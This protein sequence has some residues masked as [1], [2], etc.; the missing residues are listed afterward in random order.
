VKA[1]NITLTILLLAPLSVPARADFKYTETAKVTGG[2]VKSA[3]K[4]AGVFS[5][6]AAQATQPVVTTRYVKGGRLRTDNPDGK[7]Q[8]IDAEGRRI[9]DIDT[10]KRTYTEITFE[11]MKTAIQNAQQQ[12]QKKMEKD[13]KATDAKANVKVNFKVT[14][15]TGTREIMGQTT[16]E[17]KVQID[18]EM[19]AQDTSQSAQPSGPVSGTMVTTMDMWVAPSVTGYHEFADFYTRMAKE[20]NWVPPSN[21]QVDPR[22]SQSLD[23]LQKNSANLKGFPLLQYMT[24]SMA[25]Q[26]D[27]SGN[28]AQNSNSSSASSTSSSDSDSSPT[29]MSGAM[30]KGLGGIFGKKKK[31]DDAADQNSKNPPPPSTPGSLIEMTIEVNSFSDG[32]LDS[33][34]FDVPAGFTRVTED[35]DQ[36][37][38]GKPA[39]Q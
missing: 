10:Q 20:I 24:M 19:Q 36:L 6:K 8:I 18:M 38:G 11:Q 28:A 31:Q 13:P 39:K 5:K 25:G 34:L 14:P 21:I 15:G 3:M 32:S 17:S 2:A 27:S 16:N 1:I 37:I 4:F 7:I 9:I 33:G 26:Q 22:A 30:A 12:A 29:S 35:P 23:E